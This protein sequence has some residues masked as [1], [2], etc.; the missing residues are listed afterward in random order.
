MLQGPVRLSILS[1]VLAFGALGVALALAGAG[2]PFPLAGLLSSAAAGLVLYAALRQVPPPDRSAEM[3]AVATLEA[4]RGHTAALRHDLRGVLSPALMMSD[5][6]LRHQDPTV[7]RAGQAVVRSVERA[8]ALL[9]SHKDALSAD[10]SPD[11]GEAGR[12][13]G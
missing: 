9:S 4:Y 2:V 6:L 11:G 3:A 13:A 7:Q 5:R 10:A 12:A 1:G 8:T